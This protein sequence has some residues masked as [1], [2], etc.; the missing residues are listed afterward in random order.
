MTD[1][2][3]KTEPAITFSLD[4]VCRSD[5]FLKS[6]WGLV[7]SHPDK[8][9]KNFGMSILHLFGW[10]F[11]AMLT[12]LETLI[13]ENPHNSIL[14]RRMGEVFIHKKDY[15][16]AISY[17]EKAVALDKENLT[18]K[19]WLCLSYFKTGDKDEADKI[20]ENLRE[21]IFC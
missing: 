15:R 13:A 8:T 3:L 1:S 11:D 5:K 9:A 2:K 7:Q 6:L 16:R 17:L 12:C 4:K 21:S 19:M 20:S 10:E 18:A 14:H